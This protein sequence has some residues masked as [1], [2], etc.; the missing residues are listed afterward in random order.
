MQPREFEHR[1]HARRVVVGTGRQAERIVVCT[2]DDD[3]VGTSDATALRFDIGDA[4]AGRVVRLQGDPV[5]GG[6]ELTRDVPLGPQ[7]RL[8]VLHVARRGGK[9]LYVT[10]KGGL[11]FSQTQIPTSTPE[12]WPNAEAV[13][14][15]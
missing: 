12:A 6:L 11:Q 9:R 15:P 13:V 8:V 7:Q 2:D 5:T 4:E 14:E 10:P 3:A 1:C